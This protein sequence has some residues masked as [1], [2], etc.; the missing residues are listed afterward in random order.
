MQPE[1]M[2]FEFNQQEVDFEQTN[3]NLMVNATQMSKIFDTG[4]CFLTTGRYREI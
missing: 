3:E 4:R 2:K 1:I